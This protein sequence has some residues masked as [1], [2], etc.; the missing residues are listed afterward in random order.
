MEE[1]NKSKLLVILFWIGALGCFAFGYYNSVLGLST[2]K[3]FSS[4][5]WGSW[6]LAFI[7]LLMVLGGYVA[8]VQ[9]RKNMLYIYLAG[10]VLFFVFNLTYLYPQ[11]LGRTLVQEEAQVLKTSVVEYQNELDK[12]ALTGDS[13]SLAKLQRLRE[14]QSNLLSEI[15]HREGFGERAREQLNNFNELADTKYTG[16]VRYTGKTVEEREDLYK[17]FKEKTDEGIKNFMM[18]LHPDDMSAEKLVNAKYEMD[19]IAEEYMPRLQIILD[20][21]SEVDISHEAV[22]NNSQI[23]LLKELT[24]KLDKVAIDVNSVKQPAPFELFVTGEETVAFPKT[25]KLGTFEH[26]LISVRDRFKK[27]DTCGVIIVCF[28]FDMLGPFLF[29]FY[30]R[31]D[32]DDNF[33]NGVDDWDRPWWKKLFGIH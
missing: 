9:G 2:F 21:N 29:Y 3:A 14:Y 32:E 31:K 23:A 30:L 17:Q 25:Q 8:A 15:R 33:G 13:Y 22:Q 1:Q 7:P 18:K 27:L 11:Y 24:Q 5:S 12:I 20:D 4:N 28:F 10:E 19:E 6:F 26:T 16:P